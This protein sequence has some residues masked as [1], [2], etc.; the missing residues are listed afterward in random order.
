M[1]KIKFQNVP[2]VLY[3]EQ[4]VT[5]KEAGKVTQF[6]LYRLM[7]VLILFYDGET[8]TVTLTDQN[9]M[10][11]VDMKFLESAAGCSHFVKKIN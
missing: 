5:E 4:T 1:H 10:W 6:K 2:I 8:W 7:A 11:E 9:Q 3:K